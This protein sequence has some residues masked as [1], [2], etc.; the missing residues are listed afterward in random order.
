MP[1]ETNKTYVDVSKVSLRPVAKQTAKEMIEKYHYSHKFSSTRYA[2]G[3]F[4]TTQDSTGWFEGE[5][6]TLIGVLT[7]GYPVGRMAAQ[8]ISDTIKNDEVLELT[9]LFIHDG[10]GSNIE[11]YAIGLS[12]DWLRKNDKKIKVLI[13][14]ADPQ[15]GHLGKIYQS[16]NWIYQ[17]NQ[18]KLIDSYFLKLNLDDSPW[19]HSRTVVST[20]GTSSV[21]S[22][23]KIIG[24]TFW[25]KLDENKHRY[26][27][28]LCGRKEKNKILKTLK[29]PPLPYPKNVMQIEE[30]II[31][32][33]V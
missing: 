30:K 32:V 31:E 17:G 12:F 10:Y 24:K 4:Y 29:H 20:Y 7:Y 9:R 6:D 15:A 25:L 5:T 1:K 23:K 16:T 11:S 28:M 27:Y 13:S 22:L 2:L 18:I 33:T 3:V 14:Y 21:E 26:L 19:M 8:S